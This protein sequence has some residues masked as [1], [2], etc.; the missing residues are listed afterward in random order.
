M[1]SQEQS[2]VVLEKIKKTLATYNDTVPM[3]DYI[4]LAKEYEQVCIKLGKLL[5]KEKDRNHK[6]VQH[7][8]ELIEEYQT[9]IK[10]WKTRADEYKREALRYQAILRDKGLIKDETDKP[11]LQEDINIIINEL[12]LED[13]IKDF[14]KEIVNELT[15]TTM[16]PKNITLSFFEENKVIFLQR[17]I[18]KRIITLLDI[19]SSSI[20]NTIANTILRENFIFIHEE[21]AK[22]ILEASAVS[23]GVFKFFENNFIEIKGSEIRWNTFAV[24]KFMKSYLSRKKVVDK[25]ESQLNDA[26][27]QLKAIKKDLE[28]DSESDDM[29]SYK[30]KQEEKKEL[31]KTVNRLKQQIVE[32]R[33]KMIDDIETYQKLLQGVTK[34]LLKKRAIKKK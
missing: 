16:N 30:L 22:K 24:T 18:Y 25:I 13:S 10:E 17:A 4:F 29:K 8:R 9:S 27:T 12:F 14:I 5:Q 31:E 2:K 34:L 3:K 1:D 11:M 32:E 7:K 26:I 23:R 19:D 28:S 15:Q 6:F 33:E 21:F 20:L